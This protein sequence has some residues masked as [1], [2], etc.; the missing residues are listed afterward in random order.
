VSQNRFSDKNL[1]L[2]NEVDMQTINLTNMDRASVLTQLIRMGARG[3]QTCVQCGACASV[4]PIARAGFPL[5]CKTLIR[6]LQTGHLE[7]IIEAS[8]TWACQACNRCTEICPRDARPSDV[9]FAFRRIQAAELAIST[10]AFTPLMNLHSKGH[11]VYNERSKELRKRVGLPQAPPT[12]VS[13]PVAVA[14]VQKILE[15]SPMAEIGIF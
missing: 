11:S 12:T 15:G 7:E 13:N 3:I 2:F 8:S 1:Q 5:F 6:H 9:V 4:C 10:S 14:E